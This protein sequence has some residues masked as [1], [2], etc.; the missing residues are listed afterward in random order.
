[1]PVIGKQATLADETPILITW[2]YL[3]LGYRDQLKDNPTVEVVV[4]KT[5]VLADVH[6][7][8]ISAFCAAPQRG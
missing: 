4:P 2:D 8:A 1:M 5:G 6:V 3:A 7:Q